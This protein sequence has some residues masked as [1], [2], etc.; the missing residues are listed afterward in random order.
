MDRLPEHD[1][2]EAALRHCGATWNASQAHGF[3]CSRV[4][5]RGT[6]ARTEWLNQVMADSQP[7]DAVQPGC[8]TMLGSLFDETWR[9]LAERQSAFVPL[10]PDDARSAAERADALAHWCEGFLHGLVSGSHPENLRTSL[11]TEPLSDIIKDLLEIT[12]ATAEE[13]GDEETTE[14]AYVEL[15]EYIRVAAQLTYEELAWLRSQETGEAPQ[16]LH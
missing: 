12:R 16:E 3:L 8:V 7:A 2:V 13:S 10:L 11:A 9:L 15:V 6:A 1:E 5:L 4:A 14:E